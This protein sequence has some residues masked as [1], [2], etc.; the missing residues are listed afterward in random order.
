M[1]RDLGNEHQGFL[2]TSRGALYEGSGVGQGHR[3]QPLLPAL[4]FAPDHVCL[5]GSALAAAATWELQC[6]GSN[7]P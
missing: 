1:L 5:L 2:D 4:V 3:Q 6:L 7:H